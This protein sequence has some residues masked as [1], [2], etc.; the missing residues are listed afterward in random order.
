MSDNPEDEMIEKQLQLKIQQKMENKSNRSGHLELDQEIENGGEKNSKKCYSFLVDIWKVFRKYNG[1]YL[2]VIVHLGDVFTD[3]L[4]LMQY[5]T[6]AIV[7]EN[8]AKYNNCDFD[9]INYLG[10]AVL[11]SLTILLSKTLSCYFDY[12][13]VCVRL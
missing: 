13:I 12:H 4:V 5:I 10:V 9:H 1:I 6:F 2:T 8:G 3:Y 7:E 11:S